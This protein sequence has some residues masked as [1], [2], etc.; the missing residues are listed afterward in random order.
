MVV[1]SVFGLPWFIANTIPSINHIQSLVRES[2]TSI[3]GEKPQFLGVREQRVTSLMIAILTGFSVLMTPILAVIPMPVLYGVFLF[4]GVMAL[5]GLQFFDR[6]LLLFMP[7]KYQPNYVYLKFVQ[8]RRVHL[9]TIIQMV[10]MGVLWGIKSYNK[11]SIAFP[12]MLVIICVIRKVI[13]CVFS[14]QE[15]R[16]LDDL[17]PERKSSRRKSGFKKTSMK[18]IMEKGN[19]NNRSVDSFIVL[20]RRKRNQRA[21]SGYDSQVCLDSELE[22]LMTFES[23]PHKFKIKEQLIPKSKPMVRSPSLHDKTT[24]MFLRMSQQTVFIPV[25]LSPVTYANLVNTIREKFSELKDKKVFN[26]VDNIAVRTRRSQTRP[27]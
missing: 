22:D 8:L 10:T 16:A 4:M 7:T 12:V 17:L 5:R 13:E 20:K 27:F 24:L 23:K 15:L 9:F 21:G 18:R 26:I 1:S 6:I 25:H 11:T 19:D 2:S 3:P 14:N